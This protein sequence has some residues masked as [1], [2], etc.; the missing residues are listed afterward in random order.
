MTTT[1]VPAHPAK[2]TASIL[3]VVAGLLAERVP[4]G[5]RILDP[6][7]G[8]GGVHALAGYDTVGVELEPE[9]AAAHPQT[10]VGDATALPFE[11]ASFDA[12]VTSPTYGNRM[13]DHHEAK[14]ASHRRTYR[15]LLGRM[16]SEGSTATLQWGRE[17]RALH[18]HAW[19]EACRVVRPGGWAFVNV[20]DHIRKGEQVP[21]VDW[22]VGALALAGFIVA[23]TV[24][25]PTPRMRYGANAEKR[26]D[27]EAVIVA[28]KPATAWA[29]VGVGGSR[30]VA[31]HLPAAP[32]RAAVPSTDPGPR[33][34][35]GCS[36]ARAGAVNAGPATTSA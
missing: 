27:G 3:D 9:W 4:T 31:A 24:V 8:V 19:T 26:V 6:F 28:R 23:D 12:I 21:V 13:A 15:H 18:R 2:F 22:H 17:Y 20:S 10:L 16:P 5:A 1:T 33:P 34:V 29:C 35:G 11:D 32:R 14:D 30:P 7:A 25:V 36:S